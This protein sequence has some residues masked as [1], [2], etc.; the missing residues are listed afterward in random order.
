MSIFLAKNYGNA[1]FFCYAFC[2]VKKQK[3]YLND[4]PMYSVS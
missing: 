3:N 4:P 2:F 1:D